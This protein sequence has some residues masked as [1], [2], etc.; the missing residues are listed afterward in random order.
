MGLEPATYISDLD[1]SNPVSGDSLGQA[2]DH[3]RL[4]KT[5][6][7]NSFPNINAAMNASDEELNYMVGVTELVTTGLEK[8]GPTGSIVMWPTGTAPPQWLICDGSAVSRT[9][10][11]DLFAVI[12]DDYGNGD[13]ST[14]FNL[15]DFRGEVPRG[16]DNGAGNDPD[17]ASRTDR[18]D[19]TTGD[20]VGT[21]QADTFDSHTHPITVT[22]GASQVRQVGS[23]GE[24]VL[25]NGISAERATV[26]ATA[27][28]TGGNETRGRNIGMNFIIKY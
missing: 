8:A 2:D 9:T 13:G 14:T 7:L 18:G 25:N 3:L 12:S 15:P 23:A 16:T 20:N 4:L 10:Y 1:A 27:T 26:T 17:A 28:N 5:T 19:G 21:K 11:A 24:Y 22:N 6:I